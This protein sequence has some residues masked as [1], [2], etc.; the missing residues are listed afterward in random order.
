MDAFQVGKLPDGRIV[1]FDLDKVQPGKR[2]LMEEEGASDLD[3]LNRDTSIAQAA[4]GVGALAYNLFSN[5]TALPQPKDIPYQP[6]DLRTDAL[7]SELDAQRQTATASSVRNT[8]DQQGVGRDMAVAAQDQDMRRSNAAQVEGIKNQER[9]INHAGQ[10]VVA[11]QNVAQQNAWGMANAQA[12]DAFRQQKGQAVS[13]ALGQ[14]GET[15]QGYFQNKIDLQV[16]DA[17]KKANRIFLGAMAGDP[18]YANMGSADLYST[19]I[20]NSYAN[21]QSRR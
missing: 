20:M 18:Q 17:S 3:R 21:R 5:R 6:I 4:M 2:S 9:Q 1:F 15:A 7:A 14:L 11:Q 19:M 10:N 12:N 8:Q 13:M 16:N